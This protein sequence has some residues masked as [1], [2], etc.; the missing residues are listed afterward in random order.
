MLA[1]DLSGIESV[2]IRVDAG[3][4][5][6]GNYSGVLGSDGDM[7]GFALAVKG[8]GGEVIEPEPEPEDNNTTGVVDELDNSGSTNDG[9]QWV[10]MGYFLAI[11]FV[12]MGWFFARK[13]SENG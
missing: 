2:T 5:G 6:V 12:G 1:A 10:Q 11:L 3:L 9:F 4:V 7:L 8:V 13:R